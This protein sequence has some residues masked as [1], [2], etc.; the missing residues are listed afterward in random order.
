MSSQGYYFSY[1]L[2]FFPRYRR[3][4]YR[5]CH[6]AILLNI[7]VLN[8]YIC[9]TIQFSPRVSMQIMN[10]LLHF[11]CCFSTSVA[12]FSLL[13]CRLSQRYQWCSFEFFSSSSNS[14]LPLCPLLHSSL[15]GIPSKNF[16]FLG[17]VIRSSPRAGSDDS[18][19][20]IETL[21]PS[22]S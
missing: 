8:R 3:N 12:L 21:R 15:I 11:S 9:S 20:K 18:F 13:H 5:T 2:T 10:I 17:L 19:L 1:L 4:N 22:R 7:Q 16:A 6:L 14:N